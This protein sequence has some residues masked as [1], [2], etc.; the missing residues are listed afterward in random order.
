MPPA[1]TMSRS[2]S[3]MA[4]VPKISAW[5]PEPQTLLTVGCAAAWLGGACNSDSFT[6]A[7]PPDGGRDEGSVG[8]PD[9]P[10]VQ[11]PNG[12]ECLLPEGTTC[13][14]GQCGTK[15]ATCTRGAWKSA[16]NAP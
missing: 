5:S 16:A 1:T 6:V 3:A 9:C 7:P 2:P 11:P 14:F 12:S 10:K 15:L 13:D 4:W 8:I